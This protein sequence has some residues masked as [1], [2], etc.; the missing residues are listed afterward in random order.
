[1]SLLLLRM[2]DPWDVKDRSDCRWFTNTCTTRKNLYY[3]PFFSI[4][5]WYLGTK[6]FQFISLISSSHWR[7]Y[8]FM[9]SYSGWQWRRL[10]DW[11]NYMINNSISATETTH[12][13]T[14][15]THNAEHFASHK[16][17]KVTYGILNEN[18]NRTTSVTSCAISP[19]VVI[20]EAKNRQE[21][22]SLGFLATTWI[23]EKKNWTF[24]SLLGNSA[25]RS[26]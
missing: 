3:L 4:F 12:K 13:K 22:I 11:N 15:T 20:K 1:M 9:L 16:L 6:F 24:A 14:V 10:N 26:T 19:H 17:C 8:L 7:F 25:L 21:C 2:N 5:M 23:V 18:R